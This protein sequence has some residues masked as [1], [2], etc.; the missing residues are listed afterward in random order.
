MNTVCFHF[1]LTFLESRES[2]KEDLKPD[3]DLS[4]SKALFLFSY[5]FIL[6]LNRPECITAT[7]RVCF[8]C[9]SDTITFTTSGGLLEGI[10]GNVGEQLMICKN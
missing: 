1:S 5:F 10:Q 3:K 7:R 4:I 9:V 2:Q 8:L 6:H